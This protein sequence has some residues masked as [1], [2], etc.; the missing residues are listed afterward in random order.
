MTEKCLTISEY[1]QSEF[2]EKMSQRMC[3]GLSYIICIAIFKLTNMTKF[4]PFLLNHKTHVS[5]KY[6]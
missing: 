4:C 6:S 1:L 2:L 3:A 5:D